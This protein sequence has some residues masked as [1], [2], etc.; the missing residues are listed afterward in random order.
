MKPQPER[1]PLLAR[2]AAAAAL[3]LVI[4]GPAAGADEASAGRAL[5]PYKARYQVSY[6]GLSGGQIESS[7]RR[8]SQPGLWL[9]ETRAY[10]N[11]LGRIAVSPQARERSTMMVTDSGVRPL[12]FDFDDGSTSSQ[13][14]V[15]LTFDW[16]EGRVRGE[17]KGESFELEIRPGTQDTASVQAA[18]I[19]ALLQGRA[20]KAFPILTGDK[21]REYRYWPDGR[22]KVT[23]PYG[24]FDTVIWANQRDGSTRLTKVWHAPSLGFVPVQAIQ[25][26]KGR[27]EVQMLLVALERGS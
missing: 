16:E 1:C 20:P 23:T 6:R 22:A 11:L 13:Q 10:P 14:D 25:Y 3:V 17:D 7:L 12:S 21:L 8:G 9:Y 2:A 19:V 18:M 4:V 5:Q 26:R 24:Q 27:E 15:R